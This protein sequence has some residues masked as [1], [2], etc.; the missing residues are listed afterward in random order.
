MK[1]R[2]LLLSLV[3]AATASAQTLTTTERAIA[4][5]VDVHNSEALALLERVVN[6]NSGTMNIPG[7][8]AVGEIFVKEFQALGFNPGMWMPKQV[9]ANYENN[10]QL[11]VFDKFRDRMNIFSG[12]RYF[13][14]GR[15]HETHTSWR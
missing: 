13:L 12:M 11:K 10:V 8:R 6:I 5:A 7:V 14:D 2:S 15:P 9:G 1:M 4:R 3:F